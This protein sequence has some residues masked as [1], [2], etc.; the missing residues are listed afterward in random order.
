MI[1]FIVFAIIAIF[2]SSLSHI[3]LHLSYKRVLRKMRAP[4][5]RL[6]VFSE[7]SNI[8]ARYYDLIKNGHFILTPLMNSYTEKWIEHIMS[9][10]PSNLERVKFKNRQIALSTEELSELEVSSEEERQLWQDLNL[11]LSKLYKTNQPLGYMVGRL[12]K[13][14]LVRIL[15]SI[16][17]VLVGIIKIL[18]VTIKISEEISGA[19]TMLASDE[20]QLNEYNAQHK[21]THSRPAATPTFL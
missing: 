20:T 6:S 1:N 14:V 4:T 18:G 11:L 16:V 17:V 21:V 10:G 7:F 5:E 12:K 13:M 2:I 3:L 15:S 9:L 8:N 19:F